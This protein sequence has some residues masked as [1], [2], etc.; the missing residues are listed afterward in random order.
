VAD[1]GDIRSPHDLTIIHQ[2][3]WL[4]AV[5]KPSGMAVHRGWARETDTAARRIRDHLAQRVHPV[6]RLDR[7]TSGVLLFA[8]EPEV[9]A[10]VGRAFEAGEVQKRYLALVRGV[11]PDSGTIDHP[12]P[13]VAGGARVPAVTEFRR[14]ARSPT[15]RC[16][17]VEARPRTGRLHQV[18]R[19]LK[20]ISH[21]LVGDVRY[22]RGDINRHYRAQYDLHRLALH[23]WS[24]ELTHPRTGS[25]LR[26]RASMPA[27]LA[28]ALV[29]L[30]LPTSPEG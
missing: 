20:H 12:I 18:R 29:S 28:A 10:D 7:G 11:P 23:A 26:L 22:G 21:P 4:L 19:H 16:S 24:L 9:A 17:L 8:L 15:E 25:P 3:E 13:R 30:G 1:A 14:I 5:A 27:D 2:D 6:H